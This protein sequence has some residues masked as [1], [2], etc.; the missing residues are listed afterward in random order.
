MLRQNPFRDPQARPEWGQLTRLAGDRAA[1][2]FEDLRS[3]LG[4]IDGL[5]EDLRYTGPGQ[6]WAPR[7]RLQENTLCT[8]WVLP[9]ILEAA[10][11]LA[12]PLGEK[13]LASP[14]VATAIK[15]AIRTGGAD[16]GSACARLR[17]SNRADVRAFANLIQIKSK[18]L[19]GG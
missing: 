4:R 17:L 7:Y 15:E 5:Q 18:S 11:E 14:R 13:L 10:V 1:I 8:V 9:G 3:Q 12:K 6:G 2:L 19:A 16:N